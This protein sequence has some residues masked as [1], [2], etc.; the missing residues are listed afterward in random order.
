MK[1]KKVK[2]KIQNLSKFQLLRISGSIFYMAVFPPPSLLVENG[3]FSYPYRVRLPFWAISQQQ[4]YNYIM[5]AAVRYSEIMFF[6]QLGGILFEQ[7]Q[8]TC[9]VKIAVS[10]CFWKSLYAAVFFLPCFFNFMSWKWSLLSAFSFLD[11]FTI[12]SDFTTMKT[13]DLYV[14]VS[15][16][17]KLGFD[18][19]EWSLSWS[20]ETI[21]CGYDMFLLICFSVLTDEDSN[22]AIDPEELKRCFHKLEI[23]FSE[24]EIS[25]LFEACDINEDMGMKFNEFIVLLCLV[26]LLKEDLTALQAV[27][28]LIF[29]FFIFISS[30]SVVF[31]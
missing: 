8:E 29:H 10:A 17:V 4:H 26:Y 31:F 6:G 24:E 2:W 3:Y 27:S 14:F 20:A 23:T 1:K 9:S 12:L 13:L 11:K 5:H 30:L 15:V 19:S 7:V 28:Y 21:S 18:T 16:L 22:G 25:D